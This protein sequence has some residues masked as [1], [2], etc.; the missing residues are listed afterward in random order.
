MPLQRA[1]YLQVAIINQPVY[2]PGVGGLP[3]A[4]VGVSGSP[5]EP[6]HKK[7]RARVRARARDRDRASASAR[8]RARATTY[9]DDHFMSMV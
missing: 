5:D 6:H 8:A 7:V 3:D 2:S 9:N 4:P 1:I